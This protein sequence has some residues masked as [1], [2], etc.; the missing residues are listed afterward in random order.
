MIL[1]GNS[2]NLSDVFQFGIKTRRLCSNYFYL[3]VYEYKVG[4]KTESIV[5]TDK[6]RKRKIRD[7]Y[8]S[9]WVKNRIKF[10][11]SLRLRAMSQ[12]PTWFKW[13]INHNKRSAF[14]RWTLMY[15]KS[16]LWRN[17][18]WNNF[19]TKPGEMGKCGVNK[20]LI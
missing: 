15:W 16:F 12:N 18:K 10:R 11:V 1:S 5:K 13:Y 4:L 17:Q 2:D 9:F 20:Y 19:E 8:Y 6:K 3:C 7:L 14:W